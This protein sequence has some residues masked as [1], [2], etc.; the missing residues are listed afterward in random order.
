MPDSRS[1]NEVIQAGC[2]IYSSENS[3]QKL[4][5]LEFPPAHLQPVILLTNTLTWP[6]PRSCHFKMLREALKWQLHLR[7]V[8]DLFANKPVSQL[9]GTILTPS[10][11]D[12]EVSSTRV[13]ILPS[14]A[15]TSKTASLTQ[16]CAG[17]GSARGLLWDGV[18]VMAVFLLHLSHT[19]AWHVLTKFNPLILTHLR[20]TAAANAINP[21]LNRY[22]NHKVRL[23]GL[24]DWLGV[25]GSILSV[26]N[27]S[28]GCA[29]LQP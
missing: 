20:E 8:S 26:P 13:A 28:L 23:L 19:S 11:C 16:A 9:P 2:T 7:D 4:R 5:Q 18:S 14:T 24:W 22:A 10:R 25:T 12:L 1:C 29:N 17:E 27:L 3:V 15:Q 21:T 6:P